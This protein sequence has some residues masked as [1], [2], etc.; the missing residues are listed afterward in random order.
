[1]GKN[2]RYFTE[3]RRNLYLKYSAQGA[4][5]GFFSP[6]YPQRGVCALASSTP[7]CPPPC[8]NQFA[9]HKTCSGP[10]PPGEHICSERVYCGTS[11]HVGVP[12]I[13]SA[14]PRALPR[15][16]QQVGTSC[17]PQPDRDNLC[18]GFCSM[19]GYLSNLIPSVD[20]FCFRVSVRDCWSVYNA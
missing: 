9:G 3:N 5:I 14:G 1:M 12:V 4:E 19:W 2:R 17:R 8:R 10:A 13:G 15:L 7:E 11:E 16:I 20:K 18:A 6:G